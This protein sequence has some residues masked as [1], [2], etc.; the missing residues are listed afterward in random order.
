MKRAV[1]AT[2]L[3]AAGSCV[4][5][6]QTDPALTPTMH[7]CSQWVTNVPCERVADVLSHKWTPSGSVVV[8]PTQ[9][10]QLNKPLDQTKVDAEYQKAA[11]ANRTEQLL[12]VAGNPEKNGKLDIELFT[13]RP[14]AVA[15]NHSPWKIGAHTDT[16]DLWYSYAQVKQIDSMETYI[17]LKFATRDMNG[18]YSQLSIM[19]GQID[20]SQPDVNPRAIYHALV[21]TYHPDTGYPMHD[22]DEAADVPVGPDTALGPITA[23]VCSVVNGKNLLRQLIH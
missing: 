14:W 12:R 11:V 15:P 1:A 2:A 20:C 21:S 6:A 18:G 5:H 7:R 10:E 4:V 22:D 3:I 16:A 8:T 13:P 17:A 9:W 23:H 19:T